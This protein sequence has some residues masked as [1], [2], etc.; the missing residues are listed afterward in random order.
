M[1]KLLF[2]IPTILLAAV[3][4]VETV[5]DIYLPKVDSKIQVT[6]FI[7]PNR[8]V[9]VKVNRVNPINYNV[10]F[11]TGTSTG[12]PISS[13]IVTITNNSTSQ[14]ITIPFY[15]EQ[16]GYIDS[17]LNFSITP[18]TQYSLR[19]EAQGLNTVYATSQ[20][21]IDSISTL[22]AQITQT[23][24]DP[25][26]LV[27]ISVNDKPGDLNYYRI[28]VFSYRTSIY[29]VDC[30]SHGDV[31]LTDFGR[32]GQVIPYSASIESNLDSVQFC[33]LSTD[34]NYYKYHNALNNYDS[35]NVFAEPTQ[36]FCNIENGLGIFASYTVKKITVVP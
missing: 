2:I 17:S 6:C 10:P 22:N 14:E 20:V 28:Q 15:S 32:D 33:V 29:S 23:N 21:P 4:C 34:V 31:L 16:L 27:G 5:D 13:A 8:P 18:N 24:P 7:S 19:V 11:A 30:T 1:K 36:I 26:Y 3:S 12:V 25:K 35:D 9:Q